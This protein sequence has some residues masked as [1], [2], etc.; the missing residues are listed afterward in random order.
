MKI[1]K[2]SLCIFLAAITVFS[3]SGMFASAAE[4]LPKD[5]SYISGDATGDGIINSSDALAI[6]N[7]VTELIPITD[8][9]R[10]TAA[11]VTGDNKLTSTDALLILNF[12]VGNITTDAFTRKNYNVQKIANLYYDP[13]TGHVVDEKGVGLVGYGYD[14]KGGVFYATGEG[15][16]REV[17]YTEAYDRAAVLVAMPLDT[18]RIKFNYDDKQWMVQLWKGFY[19]FLFSGC[20][21]G[22]YNRPISTSDDLKTYTIV[23]PDYY[24]DITVKFNYLFHSFTRSDHCWWLTGFTPTAN[25][26]LL[27][28]P[29][30]IPLMTMETTIKF[31]DA[32]F[33]NAFVQ[34]LKSV[35]HI[36]AN[37]TGK[38]RDFSFVDG[39]NMRELGN[40]TVTFTWK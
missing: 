6:I 11:D 4:T 23:K 35:D 15:W 9:V 18:I 38:T 10:R 21:I 22:F 31:N 12:K 37:Y 1:F 17:G 7:H 36:F 29:Y 2:K 33:Y 32:G 28:A 16:Q 30:T 13:Y 24:Q 20:E 5:A 34:G 27:Q 8:I 19:G 39:K 14:A 40:N 3:V 26:S 25:I